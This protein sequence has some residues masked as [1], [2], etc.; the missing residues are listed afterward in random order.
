MSTTGKKLKYTSLEELNNQVNI[1]KTA[2]AASLVKSAP[3]VVAAAEE[4]EKQMDEELVM[5]N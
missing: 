4:F 5:N 1:V 2:Q 3:K